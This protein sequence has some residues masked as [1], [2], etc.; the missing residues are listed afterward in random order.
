MKFALFVLFTCSLFVALNSTAL[1][2]K[3]KNKNLAAFGFDVFNSTFN[4][5]KTQFSKDTQLLLVVNADL[6]LSRRISQINLKR[7]HSEQEE[8]KLQVLEKKQD[9]LKN[10]LQKLKDDIFNSTLEDFKTKFPAQ[11]H[12]NIVKK[13]DDELVEA[14]MSLSNELINFSPKKT[15]KKDNKKKQKEQADKER[16]EL[17]SR[18]EAVQEKQN[19]LKNTKFFTPTEYSTKGYF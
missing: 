10:F 3:R 1:H 11:T 9:Y 18:L 2:R 12:I 4:E 14:I 16:G 5:F 19:Y 15:N 13:I 17:I 7:F 8:K 6:E